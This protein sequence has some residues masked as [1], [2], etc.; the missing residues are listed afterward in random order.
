[1]P[2]GQVAAAVRSALGD[3]QSLAERLTQPDLVDGVVAVGEE[4]VRAFAAGRALLVF[5][6]GG[7]AADAAHLAAEFV[8]RCTRDR[9]P[10]P[11]LSL[12]DNTAAVTAIANDY[13]YEQ[14]FAR[15]VRGF[16]AP[17][18]VVMGLTTSG[19]SPNVLAGLRE[20]RRLGARTVAL[21]G[22]QDVELR[23]VADHCLA[24]P[25]TRTARVQE[26]HLMWAHA[27]AAAVDGSVGDREA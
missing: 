22:S 1:V 21:C 13:G 24:V 9:R 14:V 11:A 8:G 18:D 12:S 7:S 20:G 19:Q 3:Y 27:W 17:G 25:S 26:V 15:Q 16:A 23:S 2:D 6:N 5:G 4:L 10:L